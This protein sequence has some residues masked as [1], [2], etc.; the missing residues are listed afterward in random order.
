MRTLELYSGI[1]GMHY[2]LRESGVEGE[3]VAAI[4]IN[5]IANDVYEHNFPNVQ[6]MNRN[7]QSIGSDEINSLCIDTILMSPPCQPFTRLGLQRDTLDNRSFSLLH[8]L[9]LIPKIKSLKYILLENVKGFEK[10]QAR[11]ELLKCLQNSG[12]HCRELILS[13][14]QFGIPN[15]RHRYYLLAKRKRLKF[16]FE[17]SQCEFSFPEEC[18]KLLPISKHTLLAG[19]DNV[20][21][22]RTG[23]ECY[24]LLNI[25]E[26][27]G[28]TE[29]L[30][31]RKLLQRRAGVLDIRTANNNGSCCF[32]K[33]YGR[34]VEG[35]G[36]VYC[37]YSESLIKEKYDEFGRQENDSEKAL[38]CLEEL[39]LRFFTPKEVS[40]LMCFPED[41]TF[42]KHTTNRQKYRL[43]ESFKATMI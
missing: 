19:K 35:T 37:P 12:F 29:F 1:G 42:P 24:R 3:V 8:V 16:C 31:P 17:A 6:L 40:R 15:T 21:N 5:N 30:V 2:A 34:F 36:S 41:F 27:C 13:P 7:I 39:E 43:L 9:E 38:D 11:T 23:R 4:D 25:V 10:S 22:P 20:I 26:N 33:A 14:C 28:G 18:I 32:T